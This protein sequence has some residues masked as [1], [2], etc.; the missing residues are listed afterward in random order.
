MKLKPALLILFVVY[1]LFTLVKQQIT[2]NVLDK[3][4]NAA[5]TQ[6]NAAEEENKKLNNQIKYIKTDEF[7]ENEARQKLGLIKK[8]EIMFIDTA[9]DA[10]NSSN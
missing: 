6:V 4:L 10:Q 8:G 2:L 5:I 1:I 9:K 7:I 3:K